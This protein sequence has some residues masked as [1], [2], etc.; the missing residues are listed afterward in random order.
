MAWTGYVLGAATVRLMARR[1]DRHVW[2]Q[3]WDIHSP[4]VLLLAA[5]PGFG[6]FAYLAAKPVRSNRLLMRVTLDAVMHKAPARLYERTGMRRIIARPAGA[7]VDNIEPAWMSE[8]FMVECPATYGEEQTLAPAYAYSG[9][10]GAVA[11][12]GD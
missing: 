12:G 9:D 8:P 2:K 11:A 5:I 3:T 7:V 4:L 1:T 6:A 10:P